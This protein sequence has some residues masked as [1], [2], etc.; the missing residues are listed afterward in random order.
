LTKLAEVRRLLDAEAP[1]VQAQFVTVDPARGSAQVSSACV[2]SVDA[3]F[4]G[5]RGTPIQTNAAMQSF[6]ASH[7]IL[8]P[9]GNIELDHG[10]S[11]YLMDVRGKTRVVERRTRNRR[12]GWSMTFWCFCAPRKT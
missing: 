2:P 1:R 10:A 11:A 6:H 8:E 12:V 4:I 9:R 3:S 7:Q 5:L